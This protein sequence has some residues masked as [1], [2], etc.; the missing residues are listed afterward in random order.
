[1]NLRALLDT[2][3]LIALLDA[4]HVHHRLCSQWL[5]THAAGWASCPITLNGCVRIM[6]QPSYPN[7]LPMQTVVA[8]LQQAMRH[9]MHEFW[10]D[11]INPLDANAIDLQQVLRPADITD[12][13]LLTLAVRQQACLATLDQGI[14]VKWA[15]GAENKHL[16]RLA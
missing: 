14:S 4:N 16:M 15:T 10:A 9:P 12:A 3:V 11:D 1:M 7:R 2:S 8:G 5:S 6:S 13:Y